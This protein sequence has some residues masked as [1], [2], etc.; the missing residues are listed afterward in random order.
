MAIALTDKR[1]YL[2]IAYSVPLV[3]EERRSFCLHRIHSTL[4]WRKIT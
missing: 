1:H 2:I 4:F 3:F